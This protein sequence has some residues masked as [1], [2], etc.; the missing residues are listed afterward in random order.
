METGLPG[1]QD[2]DLSVSHTTSS[3]G[4][5]GVQVNSNDNYYKQLLQPL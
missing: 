3:T 4:T 1:S 2:A 5:H